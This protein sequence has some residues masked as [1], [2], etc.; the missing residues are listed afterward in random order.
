[1]FNFWHSGALTLRTE[2]QS[3]RMSEIKHCWLDQYGA[4]PFEQQQYGVEGVK[5]KMSYFYQND[6]FHARLYL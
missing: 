4:G 1:M 5:D 2:R 3:A 6:R